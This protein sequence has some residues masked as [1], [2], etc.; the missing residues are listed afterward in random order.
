MAARFAPLVHIDW[1]TPGG[2]LLGLL[3]HYYPDIGVFAGPEFEALLDELSNEMPEVCFEALATVLARHGF[4]LW[5]LDAG[6]DDYR[7]VIFP[8]DQREAFAQHWRGVSEIL[9]SGIT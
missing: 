3:Q 8:V 4:D 6:G 5:N 9:C 7:P 2:E 1:K